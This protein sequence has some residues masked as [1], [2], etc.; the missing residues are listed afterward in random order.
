MILFAIRGSRA[1]FVYIAAPPVKQL[2]T[3]ELDQL[4]ACEKM[5][6]VP[7]TPNQA[8]GLGQTRGSECLCKSTCSSSAR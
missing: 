4:D 5:S 3:Q 6:G 1:I 2:F 8:H 7:V